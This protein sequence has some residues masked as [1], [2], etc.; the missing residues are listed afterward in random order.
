MQRF[1]RREGGSIR[2]D[3]FGFAKILEPLSGFFRFCGIHFFTSLGG[4]LKLPVFFSFA[5]KIKSGTNAFSIFP[6]KF[7][8]KRNNPDLQ[9]SSLFR[10]MPIAILIFQACKK[11][12]MF[13]LS[14][15]SD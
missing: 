14:A 12:L 7:A 1:G 13:R 6:K 15:C 8:Q 3:F 10:R 2:P 4:P 9:V 5:K 11:M